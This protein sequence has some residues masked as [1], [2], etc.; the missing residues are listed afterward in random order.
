MPGPEMTLLS[1]RGQGDE[2]PGPVM[3]HDATDR[4]NY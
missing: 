2:H 1:S 3:Q 4:N